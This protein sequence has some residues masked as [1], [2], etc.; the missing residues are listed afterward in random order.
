MPAIFLL[1]LVFYREHL[2]DKAEFAIIADPSQLQP[3]AATESQ[4]PQPSPSTSQ[5]STKAIGTGLYIRIIW[6]TI[7]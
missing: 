3:K 2:D 7:G 1:L 4:A 5:S 6:V